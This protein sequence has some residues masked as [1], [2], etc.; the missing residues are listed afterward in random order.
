MAAEVRATVTITTHLPDGTITGK[1]GEVSLPVT[2][3][4]IAA[5]DVYRALGELLHTAGAYLSA[6]GSLPDA[7]Q[8]EGESGSQE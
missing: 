3:G 2:G 6:G 8:G 7:P 5:R 1:V 4:R